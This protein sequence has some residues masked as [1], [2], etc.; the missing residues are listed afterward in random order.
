MGDKRDSPGK[1]VAKSSS[2]DFKPA[3]STTPVFLRT[4]AT[5]HQIQQAKAG[6]ADRRH[7]RRPDLA[8]KLP[9]AGL[10]TI[11]RAALERGGL[12]TPSWVQ[13]MRGA[14]LLMSVAQRSRLC[15]QEF[16][17]SVGLSRCRLNV[18]TGKDRLIVDLDCSGVTVIAASV[19]TGP[20]PFSVIKHAPGQ[21]SHQIPRRKTIRSVPLIIP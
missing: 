2:C 19:S 3:Q 16:G 9:G 10:G 7:N 1:A 14:N 21:G 11:S 12:Q 17:P 20:E 15:S 18:M 5:E 13:T 8:E 4:T 6:I